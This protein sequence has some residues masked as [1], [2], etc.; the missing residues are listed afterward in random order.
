MGLCPVSS[1]CWVETGLE[2]RC[3]SYCFPTAAG[4]SSVPSNQQGAHL[5]SKTLPHHRQD[6]SFRLLCSSEQGQGPG[7]LEGWWKLGGETPLCVQGGSGLTHLEAPL[8]SL[9]SRGVTFSGSCSPGCN[10]A[11]LLQTPG[12]LALLGTLYGT[13]TYVQKSTRE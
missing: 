9:S 12:L 7:H 10:W 6:Q 4:M 5:E 11:S 3:L 2:S 8:L 13:R 1:P